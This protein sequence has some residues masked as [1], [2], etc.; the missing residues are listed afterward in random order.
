MSNG[1]SFSWLSFL[2]GLAIGLWISV[3]VLFLSD[4]PN[5]CECAGGGSTIITSPGADAAWIP[6]GDG[7]YYCTNNDEGRA[8]VVDE[9]RAVVVDEGRAVVVDGDGN[10]TVD[11]GSA[12][13]VDK[14]GFIPAPTPD[15]SQLGRARE[16]EEFRCSTNDEGGAIVVDRGGRVAVVSMPAELESG[17]CGRLN[18]KAVIVDED[19]N[20][21]LI[22]DEGRAVVVDEGGAVVVD[23][24]AEEG[25]DDSLPDDAQESVTPLAYCMV[26]KPDSAPIVI[27]A[28][29]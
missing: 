25:A 20:P 10:V 16:F 6:G 2:L 21:V 4:R 8:V 22:D 13:V 11:E 12:V 23:E 1:T 27:R 28:G 15:S 19:G 7:A 17:R 18:G 24:P 29:Q 26:A 9:G 3:V 5:D 14:G